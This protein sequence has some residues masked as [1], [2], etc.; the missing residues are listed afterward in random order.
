MTFRLPLPL[1]T[2]G[3]GA[4]FAA[5]DGQLGGLLKLYRDWQISGDDE[6]LRRLWPSARLALE[7][8]WQFW[9]KDR[10]GVL[11]GVQHNT[12]DIEFYG[13]NAMLG[14]F[15]LGALRAAEE[16]ARYLGETEAA[17]EYHRLYASGREKMDREL[18]NGEFY[19]QHVRPEAAEH[20]S[21]DL[22]VSYGG[23]ALDPTHPNYPKY[24]AGQ[25]CLS[26]QMIGQWLARMAHLGDLFDP[27]HVRQTMQSIF[28][29]NWRRTLARHANPQRIYA[30]N[31][32]AGLLIATWPRGER[33]G[34]PFVYADEV[35]CGIEYQVAS[36]LIYE[37]FLHE[38]L[39]IVKG[40]RDRY[41]GV[42][43]N[44]WDELECGHHYARSM[45]S[46][47][48]LL[49]L[50]DFDYSAP[51]QALSF[52]PRVYADRFACFFCVDSGWGQL[53]QQRSAGARSASVTILSGG[54]TLREL[55]VAL[56][57]PS[58]SAALGSQAVAI[59]A[60]TVTDGKTTLQFDPPVRLRAGESLVIA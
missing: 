11:E 10:D 19:I 26:D 55:T 4:F 39:S 51:R 12:Y 16:I 34:L 17:G 40:A 20:A 28:Q 1:G 49:A 7:Y 41:T 37:G 33:P 35:W 23:F 18:Y 6:W 52:S 38:G 21:H 48:L 57:L 59:A 53:K 50:C 22:Q 8:A 45:A 14:G 43:R 36:H 2:Q 54:L 47:A 25:A 27:A 60:S 30:L 15:Y 29:Y 9:D 31:D 24:Q 58:A 32:E 42:R 46:Y 5:A 56:E 3:D 13:P 44:P